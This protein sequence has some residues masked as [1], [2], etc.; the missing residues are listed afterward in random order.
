MV[1]LAE[2]SAAEGQ[3]NLNK[4]LE[5]AVYAQT[6]RAAWR[7]R[8]EVT[9]GAM[10]AELEAS[11]QFLEREGLSAELVG[12]LDKGYQGLVEGRN[13]DLSLSDAPDAYV[14]RTCGHLALKAV[15]DRCPDCGSWPGR[16]RKF[17]AYFNGDNMELI[18]PVEVIRMFARNAEDL[19]KL[20]D[21]LTEEQLTQ[22][23]AENEWSIRDHVAHFY[24]AQEMLD[25]R[26]E[27]MLKQDDPD[28]VAV[29][30]YDYATEEKGRPETSGEMLAE[31][32]DLRAKSINTLEALPLKDLWRTGRHSEFGQITILRQVAYLAYHEQTHLAEI[33][34]LRIRFA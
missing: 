1:A 2:R 18:N 7:Y 24:D 25:T 3:M 11:L 9:F 6:R 22:K 29:A 26:L 14:C 19:Q 30:I 4:L 28:L 16:F 33:E 15:P 17:V 8:P 27:L 21:G 31:F 34:A 32:L 20:A 10:Q 13:T 5:A 23:P 12:A